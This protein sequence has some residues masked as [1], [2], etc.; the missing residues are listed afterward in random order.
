M[1]ETIELLISYATAFYCRSMDG[2]TRRFQTLLDLWASQEC[3]S[4]QA[5]FIFIQ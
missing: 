2:L 5:G 1:G 4:W 3:L